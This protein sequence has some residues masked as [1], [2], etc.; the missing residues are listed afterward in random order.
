MPMSQLR[1]VQRHKGYHAFLLHRISGLA[2]I[3]FL[4]LHFVLLSQALGGADALERK[5]AL[6]DN[7]LFRLAE[8]GLVSLLVVHMMFG[9]RVLVIEFL[10]WKHATDN[11][12][13]WVIPALAGAMVIGLVYYLQ[14]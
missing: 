9:L 4:P 8:W 10:P 7:A 11:K 13:G 1:P 14:S 3:L 6:I 12:A 2:L 5:L